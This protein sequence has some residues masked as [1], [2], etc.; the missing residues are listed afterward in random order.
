MDA[1]KHVTKINEKDNVIK[2]FKRIRGIYK[3]VK[4]KKKM[5]RRNYVIIV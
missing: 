4:W 3:K 1:Y 2:I 5:E